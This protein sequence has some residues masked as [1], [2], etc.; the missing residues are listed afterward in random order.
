MFSFDFI[1]KRF[2]HISVCVL[3]VAFKPWL[4]L[5]LI[6]KWQWLHKRNQLDESC[7]CQSLL[8]V[9]SPLC[10]LIRRCLTTVSHSIKD[11]TMRIKTPGKKHMF[12][13]SEKG[14]ILT[15]LPPVSSVRLCLLCIGHVPAGLQSCNCH[16]VFAHISP[17]SHTAHECGRSGSIT[18]TGK[19]GRNDV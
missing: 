14:N 5:L 2:S 13:F 11:D 3:S 16:L 1:L 9:L 12:Y 17:I 19:D 7:L 4:I 15:F 6:K 18:W 8:P 10:P